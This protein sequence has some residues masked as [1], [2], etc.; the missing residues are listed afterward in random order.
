MTLDEQEDALEAGRRL[1]AGGMAFF[2]AAQALDHLPE[3]DGVEIALAGRS[4]VGKSTLINAIAGERA[5]A[6][7][8]SSPGRTRQLNFFRVGESPLVLVDM[9]GYGYAVAPR[10]V[11]RDWQGL[12]FN[13]LRGRPN[14]RRVLLLLDARIEFKPADLTVMDLLDQAAV[15]FQLVLTKADKMPQAVLERKQ[16]DTLALAGKHPAA[17]QDVLL[18]SGETGIGIA[19]L[20]AA[21]ASLAA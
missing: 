20:R 15:A 7:V 9:P 10:A 12:M 18:T 16:Q 14:L 1:F 17:L 4:N 8:A 21:L 13:Y 19:E 3:P 5:L 2:Y 11:K 6:R